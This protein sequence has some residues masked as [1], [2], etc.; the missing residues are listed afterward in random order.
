VV[1]EIGATT[2]NLSYLAVSFATF[3]QWNSSSKLAP[4]S[5]PNHMSM[6]VTLVL[7][8]PLFE[9]AL[10]MIRNNLQEFALSK[11]PRRIEVGDLS[12]EQ[13]ARINEFRVA[14][15]FSPITARVVFIGRHLYQSRIVEDGY[16]RKMF[17]NK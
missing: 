16:T 11:R 15:D 12:D 17:L 8:M 7:T 9:N 4:I 3:P 10:Q 2:R 13:L 14:N 5:R 6:P 1:F